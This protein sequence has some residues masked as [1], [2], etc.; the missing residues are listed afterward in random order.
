VQGVV[1]FERRNLVEQAPGR[2]LSFDLAFCC[3]VLIYLER[4]ARRR[5]LERLV[6]A[7]R[8][9]GYLFLGSAESTG[10]TPPAVTVALTTPDGTVYQRTGT[11]ATTAPPVRP[12]ALVR[13]P[14]PVRPPASTTN[15]Q[16]DVEVV[17]LVGSYDD[18]DRLTAE[19]R[20]A[21]ERSPAALVVDLD[22]AAF[23]DP[24]CAR[25]LHRAAMTLPAPDRLALV[26]SQP[27]VLRWMRRQPLLSAL[28]CAGSRAAAQTLLSPGPSKEVKV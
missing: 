8:P 16:A 18:P 10:A 28:P 22:S 19:L 5:V 26:A 24:G 2:E 25:V 20:G 23:L 4:E 15:L 11:S 9:G 12:P 21:L 6:G 7:L 17:A 14:A 13:P 27:G 1:R 3:N